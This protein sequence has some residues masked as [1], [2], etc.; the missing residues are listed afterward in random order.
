MAEMRTVATVSS[1]HQPSG[2]V[3]TYDWM[4]SAL[5]AS[6][7]FG[8]LFYPEPGA[9]AT[10]EKWAI[11]LCMRCPVRKECLSDALEREEMY[12]IWGGTTERVRRKMINARYGTAN[13]RNRRGPHGTAGQVQ[14]LS[15]GPEE[16][17]S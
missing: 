17:A 4:E 13:R 5:C 15:T 12:G 6:V 14:G 8:E 10:I 7:G 3:S 9:A 1:R 11:D 2:A 16:Q